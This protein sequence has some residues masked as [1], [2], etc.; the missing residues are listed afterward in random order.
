MSLL[1]LACKLF[2]LCYGGFIGSVILMRTSMLHLSYISLTLF[3][4]L[5]I[6]RSTENAENTFTRSLF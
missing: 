4:T 1:L 5:I 6:L 2:E 3:P